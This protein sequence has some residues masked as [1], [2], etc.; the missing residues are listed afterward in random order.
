MTRPANAP[1]P[2]RFERAHLRNCSSFAHAQTEGGGPFYTL[3]DR[4][5]N[6]HRANA[7][8]FCNRYGNPDVKI[9]RHCGYVRFRC[10]T[11]NCPATVLVHVNTALVRIGVN[12]EGG[13]P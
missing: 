7:F 4:D 5:V 13:V 12:F 11:I 1:V 2:F 8:V 3:A 10:N 6:G 9:G